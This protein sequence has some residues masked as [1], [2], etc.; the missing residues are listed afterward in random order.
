MPLVYNICLIND[1]AV[2]I[3][4]YIYTYVCIYIPKNYFKLVFLIY[5]QLH[6]INASVLYTWRKRLCGR[7]GPV[8]EICRRRRAGLSSSVTEL[9]C[10]KHGTLMYPVYREY[11][12][13]ASAGNSMEMCTGHQ[14]DWP[15]EWKWGL[16]LP[17][18]G[19]L[20]QLQASLASHPHGN[21]LWRAVGI[22]G[23][24]KW[25][26]MTEEWQASAW[27]AGQ[28]RSGEFPLATAGR[29][30]G[31]YSI[32]WSPLLLLHSQPPLN[33]YSFSWETEA[34]VGVL[35]TFLLMFI[36]MDSC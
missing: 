22:N 6:F 29:E 12:Q 7:N 2:Y 13:K 34:W 25:I 23:Q 33:D 24:V 4:T 18:H 26:H 1:K 17:V 31:I 35:G 11:P 36:Y 32:R 21:L 8:L 9:D 27:W 19:E 20:V 5:F 30:P 15:L 10:C 28:V 16:P 3:Y 14:Q